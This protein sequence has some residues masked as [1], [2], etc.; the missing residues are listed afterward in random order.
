MASSLN[1]VTEA[2]FFKLPTW[3]PMWV[4]CPDAM[5]LPDRETWI[6][7]ISLSWPYYQICLVYLWIETYPQKL[8]GSWDDVAD[9]EGRTKR[10]Y[11]VFIVW[12]QDESVNYLA[13]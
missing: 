6:T 11:D 12:M 13:Y 3:K 10:Q 8:L 2:A 1:F 9:D 4:C 7:E 5:Y